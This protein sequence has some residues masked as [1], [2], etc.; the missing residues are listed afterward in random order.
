MGFWNLQWQEGVHTWCFM[1]G[2]TELE[3]QGKWGRGDVA[4][5]E[6]RESQPMT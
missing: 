2:Q 4:M 3:V 1:T 5:L 6:S